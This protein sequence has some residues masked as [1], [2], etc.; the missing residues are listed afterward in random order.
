M[1]QVLDECPAPITCIFC[2]KPMHSLLLGERKIIV[3]VHSETDF[4]HCKMIKFNADFTSEIMRNVS[5]WKRDFD[6]FKKTKNH[7]LDTCHK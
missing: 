4:E 3:W 5:I 2:G 7:R 1:E 6:K